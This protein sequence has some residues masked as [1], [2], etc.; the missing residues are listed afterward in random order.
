MEDRLPQYPYIVVLIAV[1]AAA[2]EAQLTADFYANT[3]PTAVKTVA[4]LVWAKV[5]KD[6]TVAAGLLRLQFHDCFVRVSV[7]ISKCRTLMESI[8]FGTEPVQIRI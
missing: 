2:T 8:S 5:L 7:S 1:L 4:D 3:C 6:P